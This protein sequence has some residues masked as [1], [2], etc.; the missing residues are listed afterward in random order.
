MVTETSADAIVSIDDHSI[1]RFANP[2][3]EEIFGC[4]IESLI[5]QSLTT[6]MPDALRERH[7]AAVERYLETGTPAMS[8]H[9]VRRPATAVRGARRTP[10]ASCRASGTGRGRR[11]WS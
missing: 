11:S 7:L 2:A 9:A 10:H 1:I 8:W 5:G 4:P 6:L 3:T